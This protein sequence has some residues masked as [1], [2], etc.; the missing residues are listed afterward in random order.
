VPGA[1]DPR[2][3]SAALAA[4]TVASAAAL[5]VPGVDSVTFFEAWGPRGLVAATGREYPVAGA[6]RWLHGLA[7]RPALA[8]EDP[9]PPG[10]WVLAADA[11]GAVEVLLANLGG[12]EV[13]VTLDVPSGAD[14]SISVAAYGVARVVLG[15]PS[16]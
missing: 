12:D 15:A 14:E 8:A 10:L 9:V 2:Q 11:G 13:A 3:E 5:A 7:G 16:N 1:T 4:W 6:M